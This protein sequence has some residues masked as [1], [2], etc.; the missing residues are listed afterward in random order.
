M[1]MQKNSIKE[2]YAELTRELKDMSNGDPRY[3]VLWDERA[4]ISRHLAERNAQMTRIR[5]A[6]IA[7]NPKA[8][9]CDIAGCD[10]HHIAYRL[11]DVLLALHAK[12]AANKTLVNLECDGQ[13]IEYWF[14]FGTKRQSKLGPAWDLR[15]DDL[16][17]QSD[18]CV[19][20]IHGLL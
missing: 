12:N 20:F 13:F 18:E 11:A 8:A 2:R 4:E 16:E 14:D 19:K 6:C 5:E 17:L 10:G 7:A 9:S 15:N 1:S 3:A